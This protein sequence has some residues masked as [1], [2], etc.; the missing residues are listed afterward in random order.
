MDKI[1]NREVASIFATVA[2]MLE[3]KGESIHRILAYRRAA[4]TISSLPR[5]LYAIYEEDGLTDLPGIGATLAE[6]ISEMLT[7]GKLAFYEQLAEEIPPGV[8]D[9]LQVTGI[10]PKK[11]AR[12]WNELGIID[13]DQLKKAAQD[14]RLRDLPG[15]GTKS[16]AAVLEGIEAHARRTARWSIGDAYPVARLLLDHLLSIDGVVRGDIAGSL[17]RYRATIGDIDIL[18]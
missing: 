1:T 8:V 2:D 14:G 4:E 6:K 10:G 9:M 16:E 17:R 18:I 5:D 3:I 15:M 11:A 7:T 13:L 12:F